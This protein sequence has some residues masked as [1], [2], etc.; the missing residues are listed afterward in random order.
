MSMKREKKVIIPE[1]YNEKIEEMVEKM[2]YVEVET[3]E[4]MMK[5]PS[6]KKS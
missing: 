2:D 6:M 3:D 4:T 5:T 1:D